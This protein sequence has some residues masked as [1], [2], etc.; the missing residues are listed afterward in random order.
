MAGIVSNPANFEA[1]QRRSPITS[2]YWLGDSR[3]TTMGCSTPTSR[4]ESDSSRRSSSSKIVLGWWALG[5][6]A[7]KR[8]SSRYPPCTG[9]SSTSGSAS[10]VSRETFGSGSLAFGAG[11]AGWVSVV[12]KNMSLGCTMVSSDGID[13]RLPDVFRPLLVAPDGF[14]PAC[15][16]SCFASPCG[17]VSG[18]GVSDVG[19]SD[20]RASPGSAGNNAPNPL[21]KRERVDITAP[22]SS[23]RWHPTPSANVVQF[24]MP[25]RH[26]RWPPRRVRHN[27]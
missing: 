9:C 19:V 8:N 26:M 20:G 17:A 7:S 24:P 1:R 21:P 2:S 4:I 12:S 27:G 23:C 18:S 25:L 13:A 5:T 14:D 15:A 11:A 3:R 10:D 6:I 22:L 16:A